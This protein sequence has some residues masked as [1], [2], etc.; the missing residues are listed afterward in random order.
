MASFDKM[1]EML[2]ETLRGSDGKAIATTDALKNKVV[3]LYFSAHWCPP[4]RGFTPNMGEYYKAY[5]AK[6][7]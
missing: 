2:G 7:L 1:T 3:M 4:F 5:K 6:G